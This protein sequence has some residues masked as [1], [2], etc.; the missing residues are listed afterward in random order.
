MEASLGDQGDFLARVVA[1]QA[2]DS[3]EDRVDSQEDR[4][5]SQEDRVD[6]QEVPEVHQEEAK[7]E[8][9]Q[10]RLLLPLCHKNKQQRLQSTQAE[11]GDVCSDLRISG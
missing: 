3:Q 8:D 4:V 10:H 6:S 2:V 5:D 9:R 1:F 11:S 7:L